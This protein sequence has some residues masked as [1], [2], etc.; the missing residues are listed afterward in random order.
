MPL[1]CLKLAAARYRLETASSDDLVR[2]A[3][4]ALS[5]GVYS[6]S[7]GELF[8][9]GHPVL[10][11]ARPLF[12]AALRELG[13]PLPSK[14]EALGTVLAVHTRRIAE[15]AVSPEDG[16]ASVYNEVGFLLE[17]R[18]ATDQERDVAEDA[19][20]L[21][22]LTEHYGRIREGY[23]S[24]TRWATQQEALAALDARIL[25]MAGAWNRTYDPV[26]ID[27]AWLRWNEGTVRKIAETIRDTRDFGRL[28][29]LADA[30]EDAGCADAELLDHCRAG[31]PHVRGCWVV[32]LLLRN[33]VPPGG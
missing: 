4:E 9:L 14:A 5:R 6:Y 1:P 26:T 11:T 31:G 19:R 16:V 8:T 23:Y 30:L 29:V 22:G 15:G 20:R 7:L 12:E 32:D 13:I 18:P 3:D 21:V 28:P 27:P 33:E 2:A 24:Q 25:E 10:P 17:W